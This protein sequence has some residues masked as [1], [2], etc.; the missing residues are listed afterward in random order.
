MDHKRLTRHN[1]RQG[2]VKDKDAELIL[3]RLNTCQLSVFNRAAAL[4]VGLPMANHL[5]LRAFPAHF[6]SRQYQVSIDWPATG[7]PVLHC[8]LSS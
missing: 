7:Q 1:S 4:L 8:I 5:D 6:G 2:S 3:L